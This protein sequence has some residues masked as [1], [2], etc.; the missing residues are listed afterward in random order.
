MPRPGVGHGGHVPARSEFSSSASWGFAR[1]E[2]ANRLSD[3]L[4]AIPEV[5]AAPAPELDAPT[6]LAAKDAKTVMLDFV[7]PTVVCWWP[8]DQRGLARANEAGRADCGANGARGGRDGGG[9]FD[10]RRRGAMGWARPYGRSAI[11]SAKNDRTDN[12][13]L[14]QADG[15]NA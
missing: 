7:Q 8:I 9:V 11:F 4:K 1:V 6:L 3:P 2:A 12:L 13:P 5:G 15:G 10:Y 14:W